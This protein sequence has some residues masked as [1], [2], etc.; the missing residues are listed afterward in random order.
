MNSVA[1]VACALEHI[2]DIAGAAHLFHYAG[3]D[4]VRTGS[5]SR[6]GSFQG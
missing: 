3:K 4:I 6:R 1:A 2:G 5:N